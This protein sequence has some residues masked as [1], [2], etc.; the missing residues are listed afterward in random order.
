MAYL[1]RVGVSW[2]QVEVRA[3]VL[4]SEAASLGDS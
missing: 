4:Q 3:A 1:E 2:G